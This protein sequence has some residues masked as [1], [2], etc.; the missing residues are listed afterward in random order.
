MRD[1]AVHAGVST[2]TVSKVL[3]GSAGAPEIPSA[4]IER[5]H[6]ATGDLGYIPN[7]VARSL[8]TRRTR[9]IGL[10]LGMETYPEPAALTLDGA[11]LLSLI[12]AASACHLPG[13]VVY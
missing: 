10:V 8:R 7:A 11:F 2:S 1:V 9:E 12:N 3:S 6:Q 4:T 13:I 5:M